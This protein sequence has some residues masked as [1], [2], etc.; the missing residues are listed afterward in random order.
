MWEGVMLMWLEVVWAVMVMVL[1]GVAAVYDSVVG[2]SDG[3]GV[4]SRVGVVTVGVWV[5]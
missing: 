2:G 3:R 1:V 5:I 4:V